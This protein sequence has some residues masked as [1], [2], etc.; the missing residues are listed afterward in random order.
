MSSSLGCYLFSFGLFGG[1]PCFAVKLNPLSWILSP[2]SFWLTRLE[3]QKVRWMNT[4]LWFQKPPQQPN[5]VTLGPVSS[6]IGSLLTRD[7]LPVLCLDVIHSQ[8]DPPTVL[9]NSEN[10]DRVDILKVLYTQTMV[11]KEVK[12]CFL[13]RHYLTK[14]LLVVVR[15]IQASY[16][17]RVVIYFWQKK[18]KIKKPLPTWGRS[19]KRL[20]PCKHLFRN[21][22]F[23]LALF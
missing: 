4:D 18:A 22:N 23:C 16:D 3:Q 19:L 15:E 12:K 21:I 14:L 6:L 2:K 1:G 17:F 7:V 8:C 9:L 20:K 13:F 5:T 11:H 10:K